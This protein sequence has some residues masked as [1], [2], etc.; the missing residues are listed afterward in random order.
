MGMVFV[1]SRGGVS[2]APQ[3]STSWAACADGANVLLSTVLAMDR[4]TVRS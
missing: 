3:E 1:P 2:H 4:T